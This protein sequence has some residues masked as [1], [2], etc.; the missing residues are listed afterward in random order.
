MLWIKNNLKYLIVIILFCAT[1]LV[2]YA[3]FTE[4]RSGLMVA[5]LNVGQ[6]DAILT[7]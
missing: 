4:R 5:F 7:V 1:I 3:V 2:W 6:G